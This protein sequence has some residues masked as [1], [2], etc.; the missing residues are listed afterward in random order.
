V[1]RAVYGLFVAFAAAFVLSSVW[2]ISSQL[3]GFGSASR[4]E[5]R[6]VGATCAA[7]IESSVVAIDTARLKPSGAMGPDEAYE[8]YRKAKAASAIDD[9]KLQ[10]GCAGDPSGPEALA[11]L[12]RY[13]RA[14]EASVRRRAV[15]L[16]PVRR[17]VMSFINRPPE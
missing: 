3:F 17:E 6:H 2:Q 8:R 10:Q 11:A 16:G 9:E 1:T 13:D 12:A 14:A 4:P 5:T 15:E 7:S